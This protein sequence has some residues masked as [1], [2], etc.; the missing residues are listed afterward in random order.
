MGLTAIGLAIG[1]GSAFGLTRFLNSMLFG[2]TSRDPM[3]FAVTGLVMALVT[4][5]A[6]YVPARRAAKIEPL[7]SLRYE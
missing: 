6:C 2:I 4:A 7:E 5:V 3:T 1:I